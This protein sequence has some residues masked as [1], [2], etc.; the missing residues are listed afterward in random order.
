MIKKYFAVALTLATLTSAA[1]AGEKEDA[2]KNVADAVAAVNKDKAA[3]VAEI[4]NPKGRFVK[5]EV[6][7]FAYDM[8]GTMVA[9]PMNP[10]LV[11]KNVI[12]VPD[13]AGKLYRKDIIDGVKATGT[14]TVEYRYKNPKD[15]KIEDKVTFCKKA[16]DL[17]VCSGYYK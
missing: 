12:D 9:H 16:A 13:A 5:G 14:A 11:G 3:A 6:Y 8:T 7:A 2:Q 1:F 15:G 10:K 4:N 17:V